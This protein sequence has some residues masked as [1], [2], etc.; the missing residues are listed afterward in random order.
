MVETTKC[1]VKCGNCRKWFRSSVQFGTA[2]DYFTTHVN[3]DEICPFC[4][5][6]TRL[7]KGNMRFAER[8]ENGRVTYIEG[9][10]VF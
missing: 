1:E 9:K 3:V 5:H 2:E 6:R 4:R 10:D 8:R 7:D